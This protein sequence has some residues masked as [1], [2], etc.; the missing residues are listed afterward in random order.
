MLLLCL[1]R[2][3]SQHL[4]QNFVIRLE[5]RGIRP[6]RADPG[7][8]HNK[9]AWHS[10]AGKTAFSFGYVLPKRSWVRDTCQQTAR[11][12]LHRRVVWEHKLSSSR[13]GCLCASLLSTVSSW[14]SQSPTHELT[15]SC[16]QAVPASLY[17]CCA[18]LLWVPFL[19]SLSP[20]PFVLCGL[21]LARV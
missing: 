21:L 2:L 10:A 4:P 7:R 9:G 19:F 12:N 18:S 6:S 1:H 14:S 20:P 8:S 13:L 11:L 3:N 5:N 15:T 16:T 17:S